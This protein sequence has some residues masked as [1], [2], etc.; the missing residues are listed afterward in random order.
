M[1][2]GVDSSVA[3]ALLKEQGHE[4]IGV[5]MRIWAGD[6]PAG[7]AKRHGCYGPGEV[8][9]EADAS[10]VAEVLDIPFYVFDLKQQYQT[11]VL[12]YFCREYLS[13]KTPNPCV[14]CNRHLKFDALVRSARASGLEFDYFATG[15]YAR[16]AYEES[17][18]RYLLKKGRD[19]K[20][21]QSYLLFTLSQEQ[22]AR[23]TF[24]LGDYTKAEVR[25]L[26]LRFGLGVASK[27]ESQNFVEGGYAALLAAEAR[28]GPI[29]DRQGNRLGEHSG[30]P[31][32]TIGQRRGLGIASAAPLYVTAIDAERNAITVGSRDEIYTDELIATG[33]NWIAIERL[34]ETV[35]ARARIRYQHREAEASL[36]PLEENRASVRFSEP[37][38]AIT[39]G[40]AVVFY[41]DDTVLGGGIIE[42]AGE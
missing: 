32:Y 34:A 18:R 10:R 5:N 16:V 4:V 11:T 42:R 1:S 26:A 2:G 21:D 6:A 8:E 27:P 30:V 40:Q 24:P 7:P 39:P 3:A 25:Q 33:L 20:K 15:H 38:M 12:D 29:F 31:F 13:G 23:T 41:D 9:D 37:Q 22:L 19:L 36:T 14:V 28:P 35:R 17:R